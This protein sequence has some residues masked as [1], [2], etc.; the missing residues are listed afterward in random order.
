MMT[1]S[2]L[3]T[4]QKAK[5]IVSRRDRADGMLL[6]KDKIRSESRRIREYTQGGIMLEVR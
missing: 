1:G 4:L 3:I 5:S 2:M 6:R